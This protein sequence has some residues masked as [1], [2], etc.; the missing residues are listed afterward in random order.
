MCQNFATCYNTVI[1]L[2]QYGTIQHMSFLFFY[3]SFSL[4]S[5]SVSLS[6]PVFFL[7][8]FPIQIK[9]LAPPSTGVGCDFD[10]G[11]FR[12]VWIFVSFGGGL[13]CRWVQPSP[14]QNHIV[15]LKLRRPPLLLPPISPPRSPQLTANLN[16]QSLMP[17][18]SHHLVLH[19]LPLTS[20]NQV[21]GVRFE[22]V[23]WI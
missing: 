22:M 7:Y 18:R 20:L 19:N 8:L 6:Q 3:S 21:V 4:F 11:W 16:A 15:G 5:Q 1:T 12:W 17:R 23:L 13:Q 10:I 2:S 14:D 9:F